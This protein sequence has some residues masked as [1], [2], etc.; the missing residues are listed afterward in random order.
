L[1]GP[2]TVRRVAALTGRLLAEL[3]AAV[4]EVAAMPAGA[5]RLDRFSAAIAERAALVRAHA[6]IDGP[7]EP[8]A[9]PEPVT[10]GVRY[11]A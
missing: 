4:D 8:D 11:D 10:D 9:A 3:P 1:A 7:A 5:G 6:A 2:A